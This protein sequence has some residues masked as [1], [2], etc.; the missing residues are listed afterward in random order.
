M[1]LFFLMC[2]ER[3]GSN[4]ITKIMNGHNNICGPSTKH[5][6]NPVARNLF[7]Y[8][9]LSIDSNWQELLTDIHR[10][11]SVDFTVWKKSFSLE[12]LSHLAPVGDVCSLVRNIFMAEAKENGKQH[13]FVKENHIY[14]FIPFLLLN[15]PE[16]KYV[17]QVRD[18]RDMALSWKK[19]PDHPGGVVMG[20]KQWHQDQKQNLKNFY[21]LKAKEKAHLLK[22]EDLIANTVRET[23]K[24]FKFLGLPND[25]SVIDFHKDELTQINA[26]KHSAWVNLS[27]AV[28]TNNSMKF[29]KELKHEEIMAIEKIC[30]YEMK[31]LGYE[32]INTDEDLDAFLLE[33]INE[34]NSKDA[35]S[36][37]INKA[38]G[39]IE[40]MEAKK[41]F[42]RR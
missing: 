11:F 37:P 23:T 28:V 42:Y 26:A 29:L 15:Y 13:V 6:I 12:E 20:A 40:N 25:E 35:E 24:I 1:S 41:K 17:Y 8:G 18:P 19:N 10:L 36:I 38:K 27:K 32:P 14:E 9:D 5:L 4:F 21:V 16:A 33:R 2:S 7:R 39:V 22:Y 31:H 30:Y 34:V 3:S